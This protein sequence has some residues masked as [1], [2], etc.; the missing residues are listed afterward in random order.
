MERLRP[1][2]RKQTA[3]VLE[4]LYVPLEVNSVPKLT[5]AN[6]GQPEKNVKKDVYTNGEQ[7]F[8]CSSSYSELQ[9]EAT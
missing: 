9:F 2:G 1:S 7:D 8:L 6:P 3:S 5:Q 4:S